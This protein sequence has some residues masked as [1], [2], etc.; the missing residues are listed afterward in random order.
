MLL[1]KEQLKEIDKAIR[2]LEIA[3]QGQKPDQGL[4]RALC[5]STLGLHDQL[6]RLRADQEYVLRGLR[7]VLKALADDHQEVRD[8]LTGNRGENPKWE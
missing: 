1:T 3:A 2:D 6:S 5:L 4:T 7:S 8:F